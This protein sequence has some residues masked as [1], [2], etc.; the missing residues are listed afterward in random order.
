MN[1]KEALETIKGIA[2]QTGDDDFEAMGNKLQKMDSPV[3]VEL[4]ALMGAS[5]I[6]FALVNPKA[7]VYTL[8]SYWNWKSKERIYDDAR[9]QKIYSH[10][11]RCGVEDRIKFIYTDTKNFDWGIMDKPIDFLFIDNDHSFEGV[12]ADFENFSPYVKSGGLVGF[13]DVVQ[14]DSDNF[15]V[16]RYLESIKLSL[17][18]AGI[19][20]FWRKP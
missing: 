18:Y 14:G 12:K 15:G 17:E 8:D 4:G 1:I 5:A 20:A 6:F 7:Q 3:V 10:F 19:M 16:P 13:H 9:T 11:K 2:C